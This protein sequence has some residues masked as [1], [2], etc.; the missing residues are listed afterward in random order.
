MTPLLVAAALVPI[1]ACG[2]SGDE[3]TA[4]ADREDIRPGTTVTGN[5]LAARHA[6]AESDERASAAFY[7]AALKGSAEDPVLLERAALALILDGRPKESIAIAERLAKV[8]PGSTVVGLLL[9]VDAIRDG[10]LEDARTVLKGLPPGLHADA[11]A[12]LLAAWTYSGK[13]NLNQSLDAL[14]GV[15]ANPVT[16]YL[17]PLHAAWLYDAAGDPAT[18]ATHLD[19]VIANH[20]I[21]G[22]A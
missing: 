17:Y 22:C 6:R 20:R 8:A 11:T 15:E 1:I 3:A 13:D 14:R 21:P 2:V 10:R 12:P 9:A 7:L 16:A 4:S 19:T 5:Y 18:A